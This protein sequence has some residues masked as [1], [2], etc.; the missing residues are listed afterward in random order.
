VLVLV[1]I[2]YHRWHERH[3]P[4]GVFPCVA[5][6]FMGRP[7]LDSQMAS[8]EPMLK[9]RLIKLAKIVMALHRP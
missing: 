8:L 3:A 9:T 6:L 5:L 2:K 4:A 1:G 7:I